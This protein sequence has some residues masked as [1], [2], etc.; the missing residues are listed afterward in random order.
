[1]LRMADTVAAALLE[2][3]GVEFI[4]IDFLLAYDGPK[5]IEFSTTPGSCGSTEAY[6]TKAPHLM[7]YIGSKWK[8]PTFAS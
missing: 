5:A 4:R 6:F 2:E 8:L 7:R 3:S 1:M